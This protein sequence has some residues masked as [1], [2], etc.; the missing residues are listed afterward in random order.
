MKVMVAAEGIRVDSPLR[1]S[2]LP[3][4]TVW[5]FS[6]LPF[7][8]HHTRTQVGTPNNWPSGRTRANCFSHGI[9]SLPSSQNWPHISSFG[10]PNSMIESFS[11]FLD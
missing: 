3:Q 10:L 1:L 4:I 11:E 8:I 9:L 5:G 7:A 6:L 2:L